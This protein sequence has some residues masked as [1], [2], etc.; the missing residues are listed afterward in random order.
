MIDVRIHSSRHLETKITYPIPEN[1]EYSR[2]L[3]YYIFSPTQLHVSANMISD[4]AMLR[5]FQTHARY[6][7][8]EI[9]LDELLI[10]K[11]TPARS[12]SLKR[13]SKIGSVETPKPLTM[14]SSPSYKR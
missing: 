4:E 9:T 8:P 1:K 14:C 11:N 10:V 6:S 5:K 2:D 3:H 13:M 12:L 7:S